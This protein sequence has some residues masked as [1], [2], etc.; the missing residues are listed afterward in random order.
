AVDQFAVAVQDALNTVI[1]AYDVAP[2]AMVIDSY[3]PGLNINVSA[4]SFPTATVRAAFIRYAVFRMTNETTVGE[5]GTLTLFY[6]P[7]GAV[8]NKW[9][10]APQL[11]GPGG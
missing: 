7:N 8:G 3:N 2:Q 11:S 10:V 9:D 1:G 4:L 5:A 6:N